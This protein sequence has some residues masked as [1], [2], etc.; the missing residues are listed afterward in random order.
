MGGQRRS[1]EFEF[2]LPVVQL[3]VLEV[4]P[5]EV[6]RPRPTLGEH[7]GEIRRPEQEAELLEE[8]PDRPRR[9]LAPCQLTPDPGGDTLVVVPLDGQVG[10]PLPERLESLALLVGDVLHRSLT[11]SSPPLR[12]VTR[13]CMIL[14][15]ISGP[16]NV[17]PRN[18]YTTLNN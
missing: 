13:R 2:T 9:L 6:V 10:V 16:D 11:R 18:K 12:P 3:S 8:L 4:G 14:D 7:L 17:V 15:T 5:V 1:L